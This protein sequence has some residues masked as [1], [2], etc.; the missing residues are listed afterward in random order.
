MIAAQ[1]IDEAIKHY[2]ANNQLFVVIEEL[3]EL[4]KEVTKALR[5]KLDREHLLEEFVDVEI[6]LEYI[7][8]IYEFT[9]DEEFI[10]KHKKLVRLE[11]TIENERKK[12]KKDEKAV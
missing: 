12:Y 1:I 5:G 6:V 3:S 2:G 4:Q 10:E 7:R 11:G 9:K 8:K